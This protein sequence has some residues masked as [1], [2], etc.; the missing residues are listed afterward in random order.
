MSSED[1]LPELSASTRQSESPE[2]SG[3]EIPV[4]QADDGLPEDVA[5]SDEEAGGS[6]LA[7]GND[8]ELAGSAGQGADTDPAGIDLDSYTRGA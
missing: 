1:S 5:R 7:T 6:E 2:I 3:E 4:D 8:E